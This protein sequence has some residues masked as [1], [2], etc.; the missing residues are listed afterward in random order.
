MTSRL[1]PRQRIGERGSGDDLAVVLEAYVGEEFPPAVQT[2]G[3]S[4]QGRD[5][6]DITGGHGDAF[7]DARSPSRRV[8]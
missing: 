5:A 3:G 4:K 8:G 1:R 2:S 6:V 7:Q